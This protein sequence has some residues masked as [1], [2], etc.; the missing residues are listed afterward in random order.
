MAGLNLLVTGKP[1]VGKTTLVERVLAELRGSLRV[2]GFTTAEV[3][4][5]SGER[6]GFTIRTLAGA[7]GELARVGL[8]SRVRV[9]RYGVQLEV[10]EGFVL[11]ELARRDVDLFVIDEIGKMECASARF[12]HAVEEAL[13]AQI[14]VLA[15]LGIG[16]VPFMQAMRERADIELLALTER[17]RDVLVAEVC[18]RLQKAAG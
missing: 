9:G 5:P 17:N 15:T 10:F 18:A 7:Q 3:R 11:P 8:P 16:H 4:E 14:S 6:S 1:G 12:C 2:A 13:D